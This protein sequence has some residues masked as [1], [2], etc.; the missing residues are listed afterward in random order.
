VTAAAEMANEAA[1]REFPV[2]FM[3]GMV[4]A[5]LNVLPGSWPAQPVDPSK[6]WKWQTRRLGAQWTKRRPGDRLWVKET[7][8]VGAGY[9]GFPPSE[10]PANLR[11]ICLHY[12]ADGE[13]PSWA[14]KTRVSI[15]MVRRASRLLVEVMAVRREPVSQI[16]EE[17]GRAEGFRLRPCLINGERGQ[18]MDFMDFTARGGFCRAWCGMHG[19]DSWTREDTV[20]VI[21]FKRIT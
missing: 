10:L 15:H 18:I 19:N 20:A 7:W 2:L 21:S 13:K 16:S 17:D 1:G 6:P 12:L 14:G 5:I 9:D 11:G 4:R 3:P 8:C